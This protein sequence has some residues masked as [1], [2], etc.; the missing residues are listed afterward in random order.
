MMAILYRLLTAALLAACAAGLWFDV[1]SLAPYGLTLL[2]LGG[3]LLANDALS[4]TYYQS[5]TPWPQGSSEPQPLRIGWLDYIKAAISWIDAFKRTYVVEPG[6]YYT[7]DRYDSG[8]PLL[9]TSNYRLTVFLVTRRVRT[10][11][12]RLLVVD[13]DG[14][15]VW[16][17]AGKGQFG[18]QAILAQIQRYPRSLLTQ[19]KWLRLILPKFG[20]AGVD[21]RA[22]R[23]ERMRPIIGPLYARDLPAYLAAPPLRDCDDDCVVFGLRMRTFSWL[24]GLKQMVGYSLLLVIFFMLAQW[25]WGSSV[26][27]GLLAISVFVATAYPL[28]FPWIPGDRFAVKGLWLGAIA[29]AGL[30]LGAAAGLVAAADLVASIP[31]TLATGLFFGLAYTGNSA[32]SNYT[33]VRKET[34]QFLVPDAALFAVSLLAF[35]VMELKA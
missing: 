14:I 16:C 11:N 1:S 32:V 26:P 5:G 21:L 25:L 28:L 20:L 2:A 19:E 6:L 17:A 29:A 23:E 13:T 34:A 8:A 7:G 18:N 35:V 22:M 30:G 4:A 27:L 3:L 15:N 9:V 12:A 24:P 10:F 31:F 33:R